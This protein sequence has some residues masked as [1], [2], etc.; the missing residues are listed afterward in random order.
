L[1]DPESLDR[2]T[3]VRLTAISLWDNLPLVLLAALVLNLL[4]MPAFLL[5]WLGLFAPAILVGAL[6]IAPA[7]SAL[8]AQEAEI[9]RGVKTNIGTMLKALPRY[10]LRSAAIGLLAAFPLLAALFTLPSLARPQVPVVVWLGLA[11]DAFGVLLLLCL[12]LYAFPLIVLHDVGVRT[13][14]SN[15]FILASRHIANT[16]GLLSM[17]VLFIFATAYI[18]YALVL[19]WPAVLGMFIVNNCRMVVEEELQE[20]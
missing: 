12:F 19:F 1:N 7:W 17:G 5:F 18:S 6:T 8:L 10:W 2:R 9:A 20:I 11:G 15:A 14:I 16:L 4:C 3:Y 13:A